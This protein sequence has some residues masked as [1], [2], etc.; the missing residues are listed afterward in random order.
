MRG[1][2]YVEVGGTVKTILIGHHTEREAGAEGSRRER[3]A[4][5]KT[6]GEGDVRRHRVAVKERGSERGEETVA[7]RG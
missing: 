2:T 5:E 1:S 3:G 6:G 4:E 7:D